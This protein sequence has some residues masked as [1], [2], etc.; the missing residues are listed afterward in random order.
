MAVEALASIVSFIIVIGG[1]GWKLSNE[2][3][4]IKTMLQVFIAKSEG[5]FEELLKLEKRIEKLE[6]RIS[7]HYKE[8]SN[9]G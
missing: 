2:L 3:S 6:E 7:E 1:M 9:G 4:G 5:K 8:K